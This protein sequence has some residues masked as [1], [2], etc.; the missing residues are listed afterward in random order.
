[1]KKQLSLYF[2]FTIFCLVFPF[3]SC[4]DGGVDM[5]DGTEKPK[6]TPEPE[7]KSGRM[8]SFV[9]EASKNGLRKDLK[10]TFTDDTKIVVYAQ[11]WIENIDKLIATYEAEG[12]V[13]VGTTEQ[14]SG[15]TTN[16]FS[17]DV[18]YKVEGDNKKSNTYTVT[19][20]SPQLSGLPSV[21]INTLS[22][23]DITSKDEY[24][25]ADIQVVDLKNEAYSFT[26]TT[27]IRGRGNSTWGYAK[28]PYRLK[29]HKKRS[30]FGYPEE[31]SWVLLAN[32]LDPTLIMNT[33]TFELG[34]R[35]GLPYT[36]HSTHVEVFLNNNYKGSY[37]LTE[38]VQVKKSRVNVDEEKGFLVELDSYYDE[39]QK[40]RSNILNLP[41]NVKSPEN[42]DYTFVKEAI[43]GLEAA[44]YSQNFPN[45][46]YREMIDMNTFIDFI[47]I[48]EIVRNIEVKHPKSIYMYKKDQKP[49]S[50]ICMGPLWDFDWAF[51]YSENG[52]PGNY[53]MSSKQKDMLMKPNNQ[54]DSNTGHKFFGR[55][56]DDPDFRA[57]YKARWNEH[58]AAGKMDMESFIDEMATLLSKSKD[59]DYRLWSRGWNYNQEIASMKLWLKERVNYLN[60]EINK[61]F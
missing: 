21:K 35:F 52:Q 28:K 40:F 27:E 37:M 59:G 30:M 26:T 50:K 17:S 46:G 14:S 12:T 8:T 32:W 31:K 2:I 44:M 13:T 3:S 49:D 7:G 47:M 60:T 57:K 1:M 56:L 33:V 4:G 11:E 22:G 19:L 18:V 23:K 48:N 5:P 41:V 51:G 24:Q 6:P 53:F 16:D 36:N 54:N 55:F 39:E 9:F 10:G 58:Y 38:Q 15:T 34:N 20:V 25:D 61:N 45:S 43:N 29:F 42:I